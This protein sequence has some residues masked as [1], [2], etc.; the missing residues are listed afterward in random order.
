MALK[1]GKSSYP[2]GHGPDDFQ[3]FGPPAVEDGQFDTCKIADMGSF[4]QDEKDSNKYYH[5]AVVKSKKNGNFYTYFEWGRVGASSPQ[6]QMME[7]RDE[8]E[9][10]RE[11]AAQCH[12]KNDKRGVW[13]TIAGIRTLT[14]KPGKD[15]YLVRSLATRST[16]LPDAK[17]IKNT[18]GAKAKPGK[19]DDA[20]STDK[21]TK[22]AVAA[23]P[24]KK[25][26]TQTTNLLRDL[27]GGTISYT[28]GAMADDSIPAQSAIDMARTFLTEAEKRLLVV[29]NNFDDQIADKDLRV[30]SGELYKRIP[31]KKPVGTPD[32]VWILSSENIFSWRNDLDAFESALSAQLGLDEQVGSTVDPFHGLPLHMEYIDPKSE[33]GKFLYFWW[34][35]ATANRHYS[36]K[37]MKIKNMWKVDRHG[38]EAKVRRTQDQIATEI[39]KTAL[40]ERP[41]FQPSERFDVADANERKLFAQTNTALMFHGTRSVNVKGILEKSLL[42]PKQLVG[43]SINGAMFG[44][45]LYWAD[46]WKKSAGYTSLSGSLYSSGYGGVQGRQAFMFAADVVVGQPH[47]APGPHGYTAPPKGHHCVFGMGRNHTSSRQNSGVE[48]NEWIVFSNNQCRLRYLAEFTA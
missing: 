17:T 6:F 25:A 36:L 40:K 46:D 22:K 41:L 39:G 10:Q 43:V 19:P 45:G 21:P 37:D 26:D 27:I 33:L 11:F 24:T 47:V 20:S 15:V 9:A 30:L 4:S 34:P 23:A 28:R 18:E 44:P 3:C 29:G 5:A 32:K 48:N 38:D 42:L 14:A 31:K 8:A 16:G 7:C 35:K 2:A 13:T 12:E 1:L